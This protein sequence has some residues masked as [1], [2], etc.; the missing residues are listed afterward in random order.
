MTTVEVSRALRLSQPLVRNLIRQ[1]DLRG[2][3][4]GRNY[5]VAE[6]AVVD[7]LRGG[8]SDGRATEKPRE[9]A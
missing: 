7:Y 1:G 8:G 2:V 3:K 5:R 6:S 9:A 4:A